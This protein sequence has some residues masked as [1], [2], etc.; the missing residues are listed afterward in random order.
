VPTRR[1]E[2]VPGPRLPEL[3]HPPWLVGPQRLLV[4]R[5][6]Q[7]LL[8]ATTLRPWPALPWLLP[9]PALPLVPVLQRLP[10]IVLTQPVVKHRSPQLAVPLEL[11]LVASRQPQLVPSLRPERRLAV[12]QR[13]LSLVVVE[14]SPQAKVVHRQ[15]HQ[16]H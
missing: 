16:Y 5:R 3:L 15:S 8:H 6:E 7:Q 2:P 10:F 1:L 14:Q 13:R 4:P 11:R 12:G 9:V